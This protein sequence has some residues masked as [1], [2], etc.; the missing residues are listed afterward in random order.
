MGG[1]G[2][3][4]V[5]GT[6]G[7]ERAAGGG[8]QAPPGAWPQV[9]GSHGALRS[10]ARRWLPDARAAVDSGLLGIYGE[11]DACA[12][13]WAPS[14]CV[15]GKPTGSWDVGTGPGQRA[16]GPQ[17]CAALGKA[18]DHIGQRQMGCHSQRRPQ[19]D[20][21]GS[22]LV[23]LSASVQ[24][25]PL[26]ARDPRLDLWPTALTLAPTI[27]ASPL[28]SRQTAP[29]SAAGQPGRDGRSRVLG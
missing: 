28:T 6:A 15:E 27:K 10:G 18:L 20:R 7:L 1:R 21:G 9:A 25:L 12:L 24:H 22:D 5:Q 8:G 16:P 2:D 11:R 17:P 29:L 26:T 4:G 3:S 14:I 13:R 19:E 23:L